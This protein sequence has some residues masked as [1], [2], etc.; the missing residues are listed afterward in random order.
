M[1]YRSQPHQGLATVEAAIVYPV[2]FTLLLGLVVGG[3][4]V[5]RYQEVTSLAREGARYASVRGAHYQWVTG[6][7]AATASDVYTNAI[8]PQLVAIDSTRLD[9]SVTWS[10]DNQPGST[11]TVKLTY[12]WLPEAFLGGIDLSSTSKMV[13]S[14]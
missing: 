11:V 7:T 8:Q 12:H 3:L 10:P 5:F 4:G 2:T 14:Y 9:Y 6:Q 13:V 1:R